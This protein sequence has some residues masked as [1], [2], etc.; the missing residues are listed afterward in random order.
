M[1][2]ILLIGLAAC[3]LAGCFDSNLADE[4]HAR[5]EGKDLN[6]LRIEQN[7]KCLKAGMSPELTSDNKIV[8][9][10][11]PGAK[12]LRDYYDYLEA[13]RVIREKTGKPLPKKFSPADAESFETKSKVTE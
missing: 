4:E 8:C 10:P 2:R 5:R 11:S 13:E 1:K 7:N 12:R 6:D 9:A 3:A